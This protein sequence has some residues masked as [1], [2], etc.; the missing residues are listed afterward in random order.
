L[1]RWLC[2]SQPALINLVSPV[3]SALGP[4]MTKSAPIS[5]ILWG[6]TLAE[7]LGLCFSQPSWANYGQPLAMLPPGPGQF[8]GEP[9]LAGATLWAS[10]AWLA[11]PL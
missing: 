11:P 6:P 10:H 4:A 3:D 1:A 7:F 9:R 2:F 8:L 5:G